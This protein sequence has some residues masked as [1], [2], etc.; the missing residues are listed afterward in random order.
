MELF[1]FLDGSLDCS[2]QSLTCDADNGFCKG[3]A[4][5][6][7]CDCNSGYEL[8]GNQDCNGEKY[9]KQFFTI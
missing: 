6:E 1:L 8:S 2:S 5:S 7:T 3:P 4:G 9:I